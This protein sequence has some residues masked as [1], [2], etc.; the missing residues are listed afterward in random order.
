MSGCLSVHCRPYTPRK[1]RTWLR[2]VRFL[3]RSFL[4]VLFDFL[5]VQTEFVNIRIRGVTPLLVHA[6][7]LLPGFPRAIAVEQTAAHLAMLV[8]SPTFMRVSA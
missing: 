5:A 4:G 8:Q 1:T 2:H 7:E 6:Y 3:A